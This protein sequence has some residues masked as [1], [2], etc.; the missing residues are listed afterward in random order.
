MIRWLVLGCLLASAVSSW[1][2]NTAMDKDGMLL[3][4]GKRCFMLG[5][6]EEAADDAFADEASK[7]GFNLIRVG[8][9]QEALDRAAKYGLQCWIPLGGLAVTNDVEAAKLKETIDAWKSH[10]ALSV[11]EAPD[12][13]LWNEWWGRVNRAQERWKQVNEAIRAFQGNEE[14]TKTLQAEQQKW[15]RYRG[16][17]R[18][19]LAEAAEEQ[20][21]KIVGLPPAEE[22]LSDWRKGV[23]TTFEYLKRGCEIIRG[24]DAGHVIWFNHAPRN[25]MSDLKKYGTLA[26]AVG[27]DIYPVPFGPLV[28]H[29][30]LSEKN[31]P[32]VGRFTER[33]EQS[34]PGKPAWMVLQGFG[35]DALGEGKSETARPDPTLRQ[36]R[37][38]A[39]DAVVAGA[40]GILY[41]GTFAMKKD[42]PFWTELKQVV[43]EL[44][45]LQ[46][47]LSA[48]D[49]NARLT[50]TP[51]PSSASDEKGVRWLAK[52]REGQWVILLANESDSPQAFTIGGL[53][54]LNG[55]TFEALGEGESLLVENGKLYYGLPSLTAGA[56]VLK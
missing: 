19:E 56:L 45:D 27:C 21:R 5:L 34:V 55:R 6:Y 43:S 24:A 20:I 47:F 23:E 13:A 37:F 2:H 32:S 8:A 52:E 1:A 31:L 30:D 48:P 25:A 16:G 50:F 38:M 22:R 3:V 54:A 40:R 15:S 36:S 33:M 29:S 46:P 41:W 17:A 44:R 11:W 49:A 12:E 35:W 51:S 9:N 42:S 14:Q 18:Y 4:D 28:G 39:Y 7:A 26:D 53:D 10:A